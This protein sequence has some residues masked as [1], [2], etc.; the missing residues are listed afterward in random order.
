MFAQLHIGS[1]QDLTF[2]LEWINGIY[3]NNFTITSGSQ[4][5]STYNWSWWMIFIKCLDKQNYVTQNYLYPKLQ[6]TIMQNNN[7]TAPAPKNVKRMGCF[8]DFW[9][10]AFWGQTMS[11]SDLTEV[12]KFSWKC[13]LSYDTL[14][15]G[16]V[17]KLE[18]P[19]TTFFH[20]VLLD[21]PTPP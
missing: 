9:I 20:R 8:V 7:K 12:S 21:P 4:N 19:G 6:V 15:V 17:S 2:G 13:Q 11:L 5:I 3:A 18:P 1:G 14:F 10:K 16:L